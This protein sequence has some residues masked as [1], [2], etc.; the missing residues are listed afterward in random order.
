VVIIRKGWIKYVSNDIGKG[1]T[2]YPTLARQV[3]P[4][5]VK[6][7][8]DQ[9]QVKG[10]MGIVKLLVA[11]SPFVLELLLGLEEHDRVKGH[12]H[13][14]SGWYADLALGAVLVL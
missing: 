11:E 7:L 2:S 10:C 8:S 3:R 9:G 4:G 14:R 5:F 13:E 12:P 1:Y 6:G